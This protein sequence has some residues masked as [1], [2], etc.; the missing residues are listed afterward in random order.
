MSYKSRAVFSRLFALLAVLLGLVVASQLTSRPAMAQELGEGVTNGTCQ[1]LDLV[2]IID[3]SDSMSPRNNGTGSD[4][5]NLRIES[6]H[7]VIHQLGDN[8]LYSC[9]EVIHRIG[10]VSFGD[11]P[12]PNDGVEIDLP[13]TEIKP[14][15]NEP[16]S[17]WQKERRELIRQVRAKKLGSTDFATAFV[18]AK[19]MFNQ[20]DS[21]GTTPRKRAVILIVD[22]G[23]CVRELGCVVPDSTFVVNDY[24][25]QVKNILEADYPFNEEEQYYLSIV[26]MP[27]GIE[28]LSLYLSRFDQTLGQ[29]WHAM[30]TARGGSLLILSPNRRDIPSTFFDILNDLIGGG[31]VQLLDCASRYIEPYSERVIFTV[32]KEEP[33]LTV[34]IEHQLND[35]S[36]V[37]L[38]DGSIVPLEDGTA[39]QADLIQISEYSASNHIEHYVIYRPDPGLWRVTSDNCNQLQ[40]YRETIIPQIVLASPR[41]ALDLYEVEPFYD[42]NLPA[43]L[44]YQLRERSTNDLFDQNPQYPLDIKVTLISPTEQTS[45]QT[46]S[47]TEEATY[48]SNEPLPVGE[49]GTYQILLTGQTRR[50]DPS[51]NVPLQIDSEA[52]ASYKVRTDIIPFDFEVLNPP[53]N[54]VI[55]LNEPGSDEIL[56]VEVTLRLIDEGE[57]ILVPG[58]IFSKESTDWFEVTLR[59][60][61]EAIASILLR[62]DPT[63]PNLLTAKFEDV[64]AEGAYTLQVNMIGTFRPDRFLAIR[65]EGQVSFTRTR[66][67]YFDLQII[68]PQEAAEQSLNEVGDGESRLIPFTVKVNLVDIEGT[69]LNPADVFLDT[70]NPALKASLYGP[71]NTA[72]ATTE[73]QS[74]TNPEEASHFSAQFPGQEMAG[75]YRIE[76]EL[77]DTP[78]QLRYY[79]FMTT[80]DVQ[81]SRV[82]TEPFD[83]QILQPSPNAVLPIHQSGTGC[84]VGQQAYPSFV[85]QLT[86]QAGQPL[87]NLQSILKSDSPLIA[88]LTAP[89]GQVQEVELQITEGANGPELI[90][91][92]DKISNLRGDYR[93]EMVFGGKNVNPRFAPLEPQREIT[94]SRRDNLLTNPT[95]CRGAAGLTAITILALLTYAAWLMVGGPV[96]TLMIVNPDDHE[97]ILAGPWQLRPN[98][99]FQT[100][101]SEQLEELGILELRLAR[102]KPA[103]P[104]GTRA[105]KVAATDAKGYR[106]LPVFLEPGETPK[107]LMR[108]RAVKYE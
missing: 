106:T 30:A 71:D 90:G 13:F 17:N 49:L 35:G 70:T 78:T 82:R 5:E 53:P 11:G 19:E 108:D 77:A 22:G 10:V 100:K 2:L 31:D 12:Q 96:G 64:R 58:R 102:V 81:F 25:E 104:E 83:F 21:L 38:Q 3:Q 32:F 44:T 55:P 41:E 37:T 47:L 20:L 98:P 91:V 36:I 101:R 9:P 42:P 18:A 63:D 26:A 93:F 87:S 54:G 99:R 69:L 84:V 62:A 33:E 105:I 1:A 52:A 88:N 95:L 48:Q 7:E 34:A 51:S 8:R 24:M 40:I 61:Q 73:L 6:A 15:P 74:D 97:E 67:E 28:Y 103:S 60:E 94:I 27:S 68:E 79:P 43:Y 56:P 4:P 50:A 86:D 14:A 80:Q 85:L 16:L 57:Q 46:L 107:K 89:D 59:D 76:V 29:F 39:N 92:A 66:T 72:I 75:D 45:T 23:P 65:E